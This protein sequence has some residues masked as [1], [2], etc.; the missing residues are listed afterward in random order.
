VT[1]LSTPPD[2][3]NASR[4]EH[5]LASDQDRRDTAMRQLRAVKKARADN[6]AEVGLLFD[7]AAQ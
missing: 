4:S 6:S 1:F 7:C 3:G 5:I 2:A